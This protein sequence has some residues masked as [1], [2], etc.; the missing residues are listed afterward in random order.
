METLR[1]S[2]SIVVAR[3]P[4]ELYDLVADVTRMG[5]WSPVCKACWWDDGQDPRVGAGF[6]GR[7]EL[8]DRTWETHSEVVA[9]DPGREF[10][11]VVT[12]TG[13]RW[14]YT[15]TPVDG[16]TELTESWEFPSDGYAFFQDRYGDDAAAQ[17]AARQELAR[18]GI[19]T[20]L[21]AI[22]KTAEAG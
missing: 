8:P 13:T 12:V 2:G 9:A 1:E 14:G 22:K 15:F 16:G 19:A 7:N 17:I 4:E 6:T 3:S 5:E 11:F 20:T 18:T 21:A 10:A